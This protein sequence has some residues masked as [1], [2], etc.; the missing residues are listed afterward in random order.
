MGRCVLY[1]EVLV[2]PCP[3]LRGQYG[4]AMRFL[5]ISVGE[6]VARLAIFRLLAVDAQVPMGI[7]SK[8]MLADEFVLFRGRWLMFTPCVPAVQYHF[9]FFDKAL[10][11]FECRIV[12]FC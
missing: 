11:V 4:A 12:E 5:E 9:A 3:A 8:S 7:F 6:F 10:G 1:V 2:L